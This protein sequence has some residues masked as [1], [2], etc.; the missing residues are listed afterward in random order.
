MS[1]DYEAVISDIITLQEQVALGITDQSLTSD[2]QAL[3]VALPG[4]G[5]DL[6]AAGPA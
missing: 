5:P 4:Q 1:P 6:A 2:V 3:N